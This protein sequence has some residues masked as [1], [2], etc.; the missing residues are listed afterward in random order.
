MEA[1]PQEE[2]SA[3]VVVATTDTHALVVRLHEMP[4]ADA[5][6]SLLNVVEDATAI[7]LDIG[8][9]DRKPYLGALGRLTQGGDKVLE[10]LALSAQ[11]GCLDNEFGHEISTVVEEIVLAQGAVARCLYS[12]PALLTVFVEA[13]A[14]VDD[15]LVSTV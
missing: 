8:G 6:S 9:G 13:Y 11:A 14:L 5:G 2:P 10:F 1:H 3:L 12:Q 4:A 7:V 15:V